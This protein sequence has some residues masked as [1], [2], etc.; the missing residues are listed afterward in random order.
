MVKIQ[1]KV[2]RIQEKTINAKTPR[3]KEIKSKNIILSA[4]QNLFY[5]IG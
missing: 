5:H 1:E 3:R 2:G 4:V